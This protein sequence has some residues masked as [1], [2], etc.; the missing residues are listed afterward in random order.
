[1]GSFKLDTVDAVFKIGVSDNV[2]SLCGSDNKFTLTRMD[3]TVPPIATT[4]DL[5]TI[6]CDTVMTTCD[7]I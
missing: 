7:A 4:C 2:F 1:M 3:F 6:L 5:T